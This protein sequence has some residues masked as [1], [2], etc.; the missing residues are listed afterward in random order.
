MA[1]RRVYGQMVANVE[2]YL[3]KPSPGMRTADAI[4]PKVKKGLS[5]SL[6]GLFSKHP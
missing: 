3:K 4:K 2:A 5:V 6:T 1:Q